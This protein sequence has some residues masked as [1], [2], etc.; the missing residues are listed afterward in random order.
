MHTLTHS[1]TAPHVTLAGVRVTW[2]IKVFPVR[3]EVL[4]PL[5][6]KITVLWDVTPCRLVERLHAQHWQ[7]STE[8]HGVTTQNYVISTL[9]GTTELC[10]KTLIDPVQTH[11]QTNLRVHNLYP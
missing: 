5:I 9:W 4:T 10:G 3:F 6:I 1:N 11:K 2:M 8:S 7:L